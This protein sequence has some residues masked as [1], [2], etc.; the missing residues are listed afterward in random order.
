MPVVTEEPWTAWWFARVPR[1][2]ARP[3]RPARR[4]NAQT[5]VERDRPRTIH[6]VLLNAG[7]VLLFA[8]FLHGQL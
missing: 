3:G 2:G 6:F 5:M 4:Y 1:D 7:A 8:T